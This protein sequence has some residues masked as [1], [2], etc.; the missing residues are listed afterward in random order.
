VLAVIA[1]GRILNLE[2]LAEGIERESQLEF[3]TSHG[4]TTGQGFLFG[5]AVPAE[6]IAGLQWPATKAMA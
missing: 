5:A 4:C 2:V 3:L 1:L 6:Q